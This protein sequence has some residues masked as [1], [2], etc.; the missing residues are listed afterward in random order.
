[1]N[2]ASSPYWPPYVAAGISAL[3]VARVPRVPVCPWRAQADRRVHVLQGLP[4]DLPGARLEPFLARAWR[5]G[6][7][8]RALTAERG[9]RPFRRRH[10]PRR[11]DRRR[12]CAGPRHWHCDWRDVCPR[13]EC[14]LDARCAL[15]A[16]GLA[17]RV[18]STCAC[19]AHARAQRMRV[20][21]R[22]AHP[23]ALALA[24]ARW[25]VQVHAHRHILRPSLARAGA[26]ILTGACGSVRAICVVVVPTARPPLDHPSATPR[27]QVTLGATGTSTDRDRHPKIGS[28][29]FLAAK[30]S[31]LGNITIGDGATVAAH[32]LVNRS[33]P[34]GYTAMGVPAV[35]RPPKRE[36]SFLSPGHSGV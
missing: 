35:A 16:P 8:A 30:C 1:M 3:S 18:R 33:V 24:P 21:T 20:H 11:P 13:E 31:V 27:P 29:V 17:S 19:A 2:R 32:A 12:L 36:A 6:Q 10:P 34:P 26:H 5:G 14:V 9:L 23:L 15:G 25:S 4:G 28:E 7:A 22:A